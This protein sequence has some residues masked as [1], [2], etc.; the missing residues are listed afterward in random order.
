MRHGPPGNRFQTNP[1]GV[2]ARGVVSRPEVRHRF[3]TNPR[4]VEAAARTG[5][6]TAPTSF[7][8]TLVGLKPAAVDTDVHGPE[9]SDEPS[10]G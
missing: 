10:W 6:S 1:R 5:Q 8:R 3:Q 7:R 2:E 4:G 9:V